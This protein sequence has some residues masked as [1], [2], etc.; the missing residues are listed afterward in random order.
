[1]KFHEFGDK[2]NPLIILIHGVLT[3]WQMWEK[4]IEYFSD[5]YF[6]IVPALDAHVEEE[7]SEYISADD[8]AEKISEYVLNNYG[9]DVFLLS[10]LSMG[11]VVANKMFESD[12]LCIKHLVLDGAPLVKAP[13][14]MES[15]MAKNYISIIHGSKKRK[16]KVL[17]NFVIYFLPEKYL[18][19]FLKFA[20][21]MSDES[22]TNIV[23]AA[24]RCRILKTVN[25]DT[26]ILFIHGTKANEI[27][28]K[29]SAKRMTRIYPDAT[30][31]V[32][33]G[34]SHGELAIYHP[35]EWC[36]IVDCFASKQR[37]DDKI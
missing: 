14:I 15:I 3:P 8:E 31:K 13:R 34:Y 11:G 5:R 12:K 4:Q 16:Q 37:W 28:A 10:G 22:V 33:K 26:K 7:P 21:T 19:S 29:K 25:T 23:K 17:E 30:V 18:I 6:V 20:D 24:C 2:S 27:L 1:M 9:K 36:N 32:F 35:E